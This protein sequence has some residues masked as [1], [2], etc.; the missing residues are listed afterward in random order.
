MGRLRLLFW[1]VLSTYLIGNL[2]IVSEVVLCI[3]EGDH[4][5]VELVVGG[6]CA[7]HRNYTKFTTKG[8][9]T[10]HPDSHHDGPHT[11]VDYTI[12]S[13]AYNQQSS[14][15]DIASLAVFPISAVSTNAIVPNP[16]PIRGLVTP[17]SPPIRNKTLLALDS[18]VILS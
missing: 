12:G 1:L 9:E 5:N 3:G 2:S 18:V 15:L 11:C 10:E 8:A 17:R 14:A 13:S 6:S 16:I 7:T 4:V